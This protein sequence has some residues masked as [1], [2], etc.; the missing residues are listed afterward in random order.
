MDDDDERC[1]L[2]PVLASYLIS[3]HDEYDTSEHSYQYDSIFHICSSSFTSLSSSSSSKYHPPERH[4]HHCHQYHHYFYDTYLETI[5]VVDQFLR[6][7]LSFTTT[8]TSDTQIFI[9]HCRRATKR[10][11]VFTSGFHTVKAKIDVSLIASFMRKEGLL[12]LQFSSS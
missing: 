3:Y 9:F 1:L 6:H 7:S 8:S 2:V 12:Y 10:W 5:D 4:D 11:K